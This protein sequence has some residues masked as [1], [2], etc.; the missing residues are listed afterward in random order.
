MPL[1]LDWNSIR[2]VNG[3]KR[4]GFEELCT[5]LAR[6]DCPPGCRFERKGT[7][8]SG[9]EAYVVHPDQ[10]EWAWQAKFFQSMG[11][12]Q[13]A[14]LDESVAAAIE[15]HPKLT[16]FIVC[17]S[18]DLPDGRAPRK[19]SARERWNDRVSAWTQLAAK[20][21]MAVEFVWAGSHELL[22]KL[23]N[24]EHISLLNF[25][26]GERHLDETWL[27]ARLSEA[28]QAAG[29]RYTPELNVK[30]PLAEQFQALGRTREFFRRI[31]AAATGIKER[32]R[33]HAFSVGRAPD[34]ALESLVKTAQA[35]C[36]AALAAFVSL[37]DDPIIAAPLDE[38]HTTLRD[39]AR[40]VD[41]LLSELRRR[42]EAEKAENT[43]SGTQFQR[44]SSDDSYA[45][46]DLRSQLT[47]AY[48][49]VDKHRDIIDRRLLILTGDAG[50]G[51]TH[52]LCD[53]AEQRLDAGL[54]TVVLMGQR[55]LETGDPWTQALQ[56]LD[57]QGWTAKEFVGA[58]E[59]LAKRAGRKLFLII[60]ALNEGAGSRLWRAHLAPFLGRL[61]ASPWITTVISVR[62]SFLEGLVP[63]EVATTAFH[64]EHH[65]FDSV[66][67]DATRTFFAHYGIDLPS[68]PLLAPEFRNPLYLKTLCKGLR[69]AGESR[70]PRGFHGVVNAFD[71]YLRGVN[72]RLSTTLDFDSRLN[73]VTRA[74]D[75]VAYRMVATRQSWLP[76]MEAQDVVDALLGGRTYS[77]SLMA[78]LL[79]EGLLIEEQHWD[80][81]ASRYTSV[82]VIGYERLS[83]YLAV[84]TILEDVLRT[85]DPTSAFK[86]GGVLDLRALR[87]DWRSPG[88]H[89][90]LHILV[91][92]RLG[93]ELIA[94]LPDLVDLYQT[95]DAFLGSLVWREPKAVTPQAVE[96]LLA[97]KVSR[98]DKVIET[99]VT[100]ATIPSHPLNIRFTDALL[101]KVSMG[102]RDAWWTTGLHAL[103]GQKGAIDRLIQWADRLWPHD[104]IEA[105]SAELTAI[106]IAW[107]L[108]SSNRYL[109]DHATKSLVRVL[110]WKPELAV[111]MVAKFAQLDDAYVAERVLAAVFGAAMRTTDVAGVELVADAVYAQV[112]AA[113]EPRPH[114]LLREY[115]R[116]V[117][118]RA[119]H[120]RGTDAA[121][122]RKG[123]DPPYASAWPV[124]PS[125]AELDAVA[126]KWSSR[127]SKP[128]SW[129]HH[130]IRSS[131]MDDD[132]GRY[133]IGTNSWSTNWLSLR[134]DQPPWMSLEKR[135]ELAVAS[136]TKPQQQAWKLFKTAKSRVD[137][138]NWTARLVKVSTTDEPVQE[139]SPKPVAS[140]AEEL[141][142]K[143]RQLLLDTLGPKK[144][145]ELSLLLD[146]MA[147][148][149][150]RGRQPK[151]DLKLVQRYVLGRVFEL[152]WT[153][154]RFEEF[155]SNLQSS[156]REA[157]KAERIG[158]KYQWIAYHEMLAFM[159]DHYQYTCQSGDKE[160]G[161][162]YQ[163][164][165]QDN[166]RD[167]DPS[168]VMLLPLRGDGAPTDPAFWSSLALKDWRQAASAKD[169]AHI[170]SD[171]PLPE[172]LLLCRD[173]PS[174]SEWVVLWTHIKWRMPR[175][176][177]ED[178]YKDGRR[179]IWL[180]ADGALIKRSD[181]VRLRSKGFARELRRGML[182][183]SE[184][185]EIFLGEIGWS[186]ASRYFL[187]PYYGQSGWPTTVGGKGLNVVP[188][189]IGYLRERGSLDCSIED[190]SVRL[191]APS[192]GMLSLLDA[193][194]SG[195]SATYVSDSG[196]VVAFDPSVNVAGPSALLVRREVLVEVL[197]RHDLLAC[198]I[199]QGEKVDAEGAP[200]YGIQ[201][202]RSFD[203]VFV[204]DGQGISGSY[205]FDRV[206]DPDASD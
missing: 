31:Q 41:A 159:A 61:S 4:D 166:F 139:S 168:N 5:Q 133:I 171:V 202:R 191:R 194:W 120:L 105:E 101:R 14:Q 70:L 182:H 107:L 17:I 39:A 44:S 42:A 96:H 34:P 33:S 146:E 10:T 47:D 155:D 195:I 147:S 128:V 89:E 99:L 59:V 68:T 157:N 110:T 104:E 78:G 142:A 22:T 77:T 116:G 175:P 198:W 135:E 114:V 169:W 66:E 190:E 12:S 132:F 51:K 100:L 156:G 74:L 111:N 144:R 183:S 118:K 60:D 102:D 95:T 103:W 65:G 163:G 67:F 50:S 88:F 200:D 15:G 153:S 90:A 69:D 20:K 148:D 174:D 37:S 201:A 58:L 165:W 25:F 57:L 179:E 11:D 180:N 188:A 121:Q 131:V 170:T 181:A 54:P 29:P 136:L 130:R 92:E 109:R 152:G 149:S 140:P 23:A 84:K 16:R 26:F 189:S 197:R 164:S 91:A 72:A 206:E 117:V 46:R 64:M 108:T 2:A 134:L 71:L 143:I 161:T 167:I 7:P 205:A 76:Y 73:L 27:R 112:F 81:T 85:G 145:K 56:Q 94:L 79:G 32:V 75:C 35:A 150:R 48:A 1:D 8:D 28:H 13:W 123:V 158:K 122:S 125:D 185:H 113:G 129:G 124:I 176:A 19:K 184:N 115:A 204:W 192:E 62:S 18:C 45:L 160:I 138:A 63:D 55:F 86:R 177:Y 80:D 187:D 9:V 93:E 126:P 137:M 203:G 162:A 119:D 193:R 154:E 151:F 173:A 141:L 38:L 49:I 172:E 87:E 30:L 36:N 43:A 53:L 106:A 21:A 127:A 196:S 178:S 52:L 98:K 6:A 186:E 199:L 40:R 83:D 24:P 82:V 3:S 97:L